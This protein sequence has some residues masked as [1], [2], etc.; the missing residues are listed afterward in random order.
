[1]TILDIIKTGGVILYP[2]DTLWGLGGDAT[3]D[4]PAL[5][6]RQIKGREAD[7]PFIVLVSDLDMLRSLVGEIPPAVMNEMEKSIRPLTVIYPRGYGVSA[8]VKAA[9]GSLAVRVVKKGFARDLIRVVNRPLI[10]TSAN[11]SGQ[12][13]PA[14]FEE[15]P[16]DIL[17]SV[18]YV[19][20]LHRSK[21][22][23]R[24]SRII[25]FDEQGRIQVIRE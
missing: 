14:S 2:S 1:M 4:K 6:I 5:R 23:A 7:K 16:E 17:R 13:A 8:H 22:G 12:P 10:S 18:D 24:P 3:Q 25:R 11:L 19:V 9:D 20:N 21:T 15:I